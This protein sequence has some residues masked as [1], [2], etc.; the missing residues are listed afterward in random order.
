MKLPKPSHREAIALFRLGVV[1][2]LLT[3]ELKRGELRSELM[4]RARQRY[5]PPR[6]NRSRRY[7]HK[8]LQRW[9]YEAKRD[10]V[11]GLLPPDANKPEIR[12][13]KTGSRS[14]TSLAEATGPEE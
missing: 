12:V 9:Y 8:T 10:L 5:R 11:G 7:H 13:G 3:R 6:A 1:G 4:S 14:V 2:D